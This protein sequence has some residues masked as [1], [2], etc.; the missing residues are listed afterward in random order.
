MGIGEVLSKERF[1]NG[2]KN[3]SKLRA[4]VSHGS[5]MTF[6]ALILILL[7]AFVIR[8]MPVKWEIQS[9]SIH[10]SEFDPY[11]QFR[12]TQYIVNNGFI[13]WNWPSPG[14]N[15]T[16][17]WYPWGMLVAKQGYPGLPFTTAFLYKIVA[18]LGVNIDLMTFCAVIPPIMGMLA[19][20]AIYFL[21][22][23]IGGKTVGLFAA[24][25][26]AL[27]PSFLQRTALG[28]FDDETIGILALIIFLIL[29]LRAIDEDKPQSSSM[30]YAIGSG[31][32]LGYFSAG[33]GAAYYP[34]DATAL[35]VLVLILLKRYSQRLLLSYGLTFGIGMFIAMNV[36][37]LSPTYLAT[38]PI[39][40]VAGVFVLLC[41]YE[42]S[43]VL[44]TMKLKFLFIAAF[45][46]L[47]IG[48]FAVFWQLGYMQE[49]AGKFWSVVNPFA[50]TVSPLTESVAEHRISA[51]GSIYYEFGI[52]IIFFITG[53]F[54]VLRNL[55]NRNLFLLILGLTSLY[56]AS[57]M[58]R[59]F[60]LLAPIFSLLGAIGIVGILKPFITLFKEPPKITT[61]KKYSLDYVG[62]EFSGMTILLIFLILMTNFAFA[63]Q[64]G[65]MPK[66]YRQAYTPITITTGS[67]PIVPSEP[68]REWIDMLDYTRKLGASTVVVSWW[69]YGY[70]LTVL[71][72]VTT[73]CDN[74]TKNGTQIENVG[75]IFIANET[76]SI[77][78]LREY[79]A[80]YILVFTTIDTNGNWA[81]SGDEGK[82]PWMVR[83]SGKGQARLMN[84]GFMDPS[85]PWGDTLEDAAKF[86]NQTLGSD[87]KDLNK[88]GTISQDELIANPRGQNTT[89]YKLM[90]YARNRWIETHKGGSPPQEPEYFKEAFIAGLSLKPEEAGKYG[91]II[92]L[93]ALY[94]IQYPTS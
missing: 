58:V 10:L 23:D 18:A 11:F 39:L 15:D 51:W 55:N 48:G 47:L 53:F 42:I 40:A 90:V 89:I 70:W 59:L 34:I 31:L 79:R 75:F 27:S 17:R 77:K 9:G 35:F 37:K 38:A 62:R 69:D 2:L 41:V 72:N 68:V 8:M 83:I 26:L 4:K 25:F 22:K 21:G 45:L 28:F 3:L 1:V 71:G 61:K 78:M 16:Q 19:S 67:L 66:V 32:A 84:S 36:P 49:I 76:Q 5:I 73:L 86:G 20:L 91:N 43:R 12:F 14:W 54:F 56:F 94:K 80:E 33:W 63:P 60:V 93:V 29:F 50:R 7:T 52:G 88:D 85:N 30:M 13:S 64:T 82:W 92:P 24:L 46:A 6:S 44:T 74:A 81:G 65:G 87:G 57:S